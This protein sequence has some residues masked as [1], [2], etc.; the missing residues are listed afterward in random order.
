MDYYSN[1][2]IRTKLKDIKSKKINNIKGLLYIILIIIISSILHKIPPV[3]LI[4]VIWTLILRIILLFNILFMPTKIS[5]IF[6]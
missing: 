1:F 6:L 5:K 3:L 2:L 4:I